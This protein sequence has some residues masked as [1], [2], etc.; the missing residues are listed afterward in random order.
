MLSVYLFFLTWIPKQRFDKMFAQLTPMVYKKGCHVN[1][2]HPSALSE[3]SLTTACTTNTVSNTQK[4]WQTVVTCSHS[5]FPRLGCATVLVTFVMYCWDDVVVRSKDLRPSGSRLDRLTPMFG[6]ATG[7]QCGP[8]SAGVADLFDPPIFIRLCR[9]DVWNLEW[10]CVIWHKHGQIKG[11]ELRKN[12][13]QIINK[14][15]CRIFIYNKFLLVW[16][17]GTFVKKCI[18]SLGNHL[19]REWVFICI[20]DNSS[21]DNIRSRKLMI[22]IFPV[23]SCH[24]MIELAL[25][26]SGFEIE[27]IMSYWWNKDRSYS[28]VSSIGIFGSYGISQ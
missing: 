23:E 25:K 26:L 14:Y 8:K 7:S 22:V 2:C 15:P 17:G 6:M 9:S 24:I 18:S 21:T 20:C 13:V 10:V 5:T 11:S 1:C 4:T 12:V 3:A 19:F 16:K 27:N 28:K